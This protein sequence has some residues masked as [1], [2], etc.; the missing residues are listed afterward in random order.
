MVDRERAAAL[1]GT[2]ER[3]NLWRRGQSGAEQPDPFEFGAAID[4]AVTALRALSAPVSDERTAIVPREPTGGMLDA[5]WRA[6]GRHSAMGPP[7]VADIYVSTI[8]ASEETA[9]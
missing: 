1:A 9:G 3:A 7:C 2:L 8:K 6:A 4:E 5:G